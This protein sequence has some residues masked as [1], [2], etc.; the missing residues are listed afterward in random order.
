MTVTIGFDWDEAGGYYAAVGDSSRVLAHGKMTADIPGLLGF[1]GLFH[2]HAE[3]DG[4]LPTM[5]MEAS[6]RPIVDAL[7]DHGV[8][9]LACNPNELNMR[10]KGRN[11]LKS[12]RKDAL[13]LVQTYRIEPE[14][15][16]PVPQPTV[17]S[18]E[19]TLLAREGKDS[20]FAVHRAAGR[21]RSLLV[22][23]FPNALDAWSPIDLANKP[24]A[25]AILIAFPTPTEAQ[26][27]TADQI[28]EVV[29]A[30]GKHSHIQLAVDKALKAFARPRVQYATALE[31]SYGLVLQGLL[32]ELQAAMGHRKAIQERLDALV[33]EHPLGKVL[34]EAPGIGISVAARI[35]GEMGDD[36][37]RFRDKRG[38][39]AFSGMAP[40]LSQTG[41]S[42]GHHTRRQ[43]RGNRLHAAIW[44]MAGSA[45]QHSPGAIAYYWRKHAEGDQHPTALRKV[46]RRLSHGLWHVA[47]NGDAWS[48]ALLWPSAPETKAEALVYADDVREQLGKARKRP[49]PGTD[50]EPVDL[51]DVA[52]ALGALLPTGRPSAHVPAGAG[53]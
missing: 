25:A 29:V 32:W 3:A 43:V 48:E 47:K 19:I 51:R 21:A 41:K 34:L 39:A 26:A 40:V 1:V 33:P 27:A 13:R 50:P 30:T 46:G 49:K 37:Q 8:T 18:R 24:E 28:R 10:S 52:S 22:E 16:R 23:F 4:T 36:P 5:V 6:R 11:K 2:E 53:H 14:R 7:I 35:L 20:V 44:D 12:D 31:K 9:V 42:S 15:F 38:L 17:R 45:V